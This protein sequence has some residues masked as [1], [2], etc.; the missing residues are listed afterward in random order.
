VRYKKGNCPYFSTVDLMG[1]AS[2]SIPFWQPQIGRRES[3]FLD[4]VLT[5]NFLNDGEVTAQFERRLCELLGAKH[6]IA[7]TSGT[8]A[9]F[10]ALIACGIKAGDEVLVPDVTFIATANAVTMAGATP[11]LVDVDPN[12]I[13]MCPKA[14]AVAITRKTRAIVPVHLSGRAADMSSLCD[15]A[16]RH[17]LRI[18]EDAAEALASHSRDRRALGTIG[19]A[20]CFSFSPNK[21]ITTGQGGAVVTN[22]DAIASRLREIKDQGR[23][24][25]G[26]GGDDVHVSVGFNFKFT[27]LQAAVG[28][29]QL[30]LLGI[31]RRRVRQIYESY[32][33][34]LAGIDGIRLIGFDEY[35]SPLW[36]DG[37]AERRDELDAHLRAHNIYGRRFWH[38]L[39]TQAPYRRS[40]AKLKHS[41]ELAPRAYW[42]PS[43]FLMTN[44]DVGRVCDLVRSFYSAGELRRAEAA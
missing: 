10:A 21:M 32:R 4:E 31:R 27:N 29:G 17:K 33:E 22:D 19:D 30:D 2:R 20:G 18:V 15:L 9:L 7:T 37:I 3:R 40:G 24:T 12:T 23:P 41:S 38:A 43:S 36:V 11:V 39:H 26:T 16:R 8:T 34:M 28:L 35:E 6:V 14:A 42:L 1:R 13:T 44:D 5:S 25:R